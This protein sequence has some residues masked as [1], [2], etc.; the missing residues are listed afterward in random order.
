LQSVAEVGI[1]NKL[2]IEL[3]YGNSK[4]IFHYM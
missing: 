3:L 1:R 2:S 4:N